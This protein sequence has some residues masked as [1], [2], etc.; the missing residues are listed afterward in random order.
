MK[1][2]VKCA[3]QCQQIQVDRQLD[4]RVCTN[5]KLKE[6]TQKCSTP[7]GGIEPTTTRLK[8]GRSATELQRLRVCIRT[9]E[10]FVGCIYVLHSDL[11]Y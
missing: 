8:A 5:T 10:M 6:Q 2:R 1:L 4:F 11:V 7:M 3:V 9:I